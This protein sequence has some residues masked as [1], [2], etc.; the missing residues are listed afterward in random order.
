MKIDLKLW[1]RK[2]STWHFPN[3]RSLCCQTKESTLKFAW[4]ELHI[5]NLFVWTLIW[6]IAHKKNDWKPAR[7]YWRVDSFYVLE[8]ESCGS[9]KNQINTYG[10]PSVFERAQKCTK[11]TH[12]HTHKR[13]TN[14]IKLLI[15]YA[16][17][18][19]NLRKFC[20]YRLLPLPLPPKPNEY[21]STEQTQIWLKQ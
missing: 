9:L 11:H 14:K 20:R 15:L 6:K 19:I 21:N 8:G 18:N 17:I 5:L 10:S 7:P 16:C 13:S 4:M 2:I 12:I 1:R 3:G